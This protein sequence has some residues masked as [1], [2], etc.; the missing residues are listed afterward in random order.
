MTYVCPFC[1]REFDKS[2]MVAKHS[3]SCWRERNPN[4]KSKDAPVGETTETKRIND[5]VANFFTS[6]QKEN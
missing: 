2:E 4:H 5:D 1:F 6:F 3:L